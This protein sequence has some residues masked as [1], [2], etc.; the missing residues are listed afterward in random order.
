[1]H[2]PDEH[3][4]G[5]FSTIKFFSFAL[6]TLRVNR[7]AR[8]LQARILYLRENLNEIYTSSF[9]SRSWNNGAEHLYEFNCVI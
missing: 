3:V 2:P 1:M 5:V 9:I 8:V 7:G 6:Q 4:I